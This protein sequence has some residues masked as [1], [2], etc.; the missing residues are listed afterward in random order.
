MDFTAGGIALIPVIVGLV[1]IVKRLGLN[2]K[3]APLVS[4]VF[5]VVAGIVYLSPGNVQMGVL[6]GIVMGLAAV[7]LYSGVKNTKEGLNP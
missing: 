7:G 5:G 1:E 2:D 6:Q 4:L 3:F